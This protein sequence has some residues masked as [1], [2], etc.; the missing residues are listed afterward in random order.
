MLFIEHKGFN[1]SIMRAERLIGDYVHELPPGRRIEV[2]PVDAFEKPLDNWIKGAG[3]Y[4]VPVEAEWGLWFD[5]RGNDVL[6]TAVLTS[7]KGMNPITGQRSNGFSLERYEE[8]CPIHKTKFKDGLFCV[9]RQILLKAEIPADHTY[10]WKRILLIQ[11]NYT[12]TGWEY[13]GMTFP[14]INLTYVAAYLEDLDV[15]VAILDAK[16]ENL[17]YKQLK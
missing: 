12:A 9:R 11:P 4:V 7:I 16:V 13:Y 3:N 15:E 10:Q 5:W 6:N 2:Y 1:V 8:N 14:P 17:N